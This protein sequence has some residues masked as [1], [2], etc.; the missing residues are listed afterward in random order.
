M[1]E[2]FISL[3]CEFIMDVRR[4]FYGDNKGKEKVIRREKRKVERMDILRRV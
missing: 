1:T 4:R 3:S 2:I